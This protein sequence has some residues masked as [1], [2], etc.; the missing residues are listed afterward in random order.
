D[1]PLFAVR[2]G[3]LRGRP[4]YRLRA[5]VRAEAV[6]VGRGRGHLR[7]PAPQERRGAVFAAIASPVRVEANPVMA[8]RV[9]AI[10]AQVAAKT[11]SMPGPRPGM[12]SLRGHRGGR[13]FN[14]SRS[15]LPGSTP[16]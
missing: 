13:S 4:L 5:M 7:R 3:R 16:A 10:H 11:T 15:S 8:G 1:R 6:P 12:T 14:A 2:R 9:H